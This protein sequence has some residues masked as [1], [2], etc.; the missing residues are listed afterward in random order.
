MSDDL[1]KDLNK[2][3]QRTGSTD[4]LNDKRIRGK[5]EKLWDAHLSSD[6]DESVER[7]NARNTAIRVSKGV[8]VRGGK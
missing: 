8:K 5:L 2:S 6:K 4:R 3:N 7:M 1:L